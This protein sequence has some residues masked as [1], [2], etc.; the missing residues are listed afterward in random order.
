[1]QKKIPI[2]NG[3]KNSCGAFNQAAVNLC[4]WKMNFPNF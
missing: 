2:K 3:L 4:G 1:M